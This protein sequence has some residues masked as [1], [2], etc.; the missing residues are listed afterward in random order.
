[1]HKS[2]DPRQG[3]RRFP[4]FIEVTENQFEMFL[5]MGMT[6][7]EIEDYRKI[8]TT[9]LNTI[10]FAKNQTLE[11][12]KKVFKTFNNVNKRIQKLKS[13]E[14]NEVKDVEFKE[15]IDA[16]FVEFVEDEKDED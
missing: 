7:G 12:H 4:V 3:Y 10:E 2:E 8:A 1:M 15:V 14:E 13:S 9:N 11:N 5:S 6:D 16:E